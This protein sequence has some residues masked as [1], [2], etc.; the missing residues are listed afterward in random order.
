MRRNPTGYLGSK[1]LDVRKYYPINNDYAAILNFWGYMSNHVPAAYFSCAV[2]DLHDEQSYI[3]RIGK[4]LYKFEVSTPPFR[5][6]KQVCRQLSIELPKSGKKFY[7]GFKEAVKIVIAYTQEFFL[8]K[9]EPDDKAF[10]LLRGLQHEMKPELRRRT[11]ESWTDSTFQASLYGDF[12]YGTEVFKE[13]I[14]AADV[15]D[16]SELNPY[17]EI[18]DNYSDEILIFTGEFEKY[19]IHEVDRSTGK[20]RVPYEEKKKAEIALREV[21]AK[22]YKTDDFEVTFWSATY[23]INILLSLS[24]ASYIEADTTDELSRILKDRMNVLRERTDAESIKQYK[25]IEKNMNSL[26]TAYD[27]LFDIRFA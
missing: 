1:R 23:S 3:T 7:D 22:I 11:L 10:W 4:E 2:A 14:I 26:I 21:I 13:N 6:L 25:S 17:L 19:E 5:M 9:E 16:Y 18:T 24:G 15:V 8:K 12:L 27:R 20:I